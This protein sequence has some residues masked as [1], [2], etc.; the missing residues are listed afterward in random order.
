M[1]PWR[2]HFNR[3]SASV[4]SVISVLI[5]SALLTL[6][7]A[8]AQDSAPPVQK[9]GPV[10]EQESKP[11]AA[12]TPVASV[13]DP[14]F[15][16][17]RQAITP[18]GLQ[19]IFESRVYG[20]AFGENGDSIYAATAGQ[21]GSFIYQINL[22]TNQMM[23]VV[24]AP[25][26]PGMQGLTFDPVKCAALMSGLAGGGKKGNS[27][28]QLLALSDHSAVVADG[29]GSHQVGAVAVGKAKN[30]HGQRLAVMALT[31]DD[32]AAVI[33][34][35]TSTALQRIKTGVAPFGVAISADSSVAYVSNWGGRFPK[36][37]EQTAATGPE[38]NADQVLVDERGVLS[39]GTVSRIDLP[40][41]QVTA[42]IDVGLHPSGLAWDEGHRRLYVANS[43]SDSISVV[44]TATN[45]LLETF[46]V[47][48]FS[49]RVAGVAPESV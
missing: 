38:P 30:S 12:A 44:D 11:A 31:F 27:A 1:Y 20:V 37:G 47:Q 5:C 13:V 42:S 29:L 22:K 17:S 33:D 8:A 34:V 40:S 46:V 15:I 32:E 41:G 9:M 23:K 18:A 39:S 19:S 14:G 21:T 24:S 25:A 36:T 10:G 49:R 2:S 7:G 26:T 4:P 16:P 3:I 48:P 28:G 35:D 45:R 6:H 43:N